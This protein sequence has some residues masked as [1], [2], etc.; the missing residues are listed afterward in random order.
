MSREND[1]FN[2]CSKSLQGTAK[3]CKELLNKNRAGFTVQKSGERL[4]LAYF[5]SFF[6]AQS[7]PYMVQEHNTKRYFGTLQL[8][9]SLL[10]AFLS[11]F[12]VQSQPI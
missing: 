8:R 1:R 9:E 12:T 3:I 5:F 6:T 4:L 10:L 7:Q 11:F 2:P